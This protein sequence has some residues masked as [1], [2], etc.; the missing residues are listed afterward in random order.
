MPRIILV[1]GGSRGLGLAI[2]K[3]F[4]NNNDIVYIAYCNHLPE[5][6]TNPNAHLIKCDITKEE[7]IINMTL[8]LWIHHHLVVAIKMK[9]GV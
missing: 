9:S 7:E 6:L 3:L 2:S 8:L 4:L 1:T 5:H